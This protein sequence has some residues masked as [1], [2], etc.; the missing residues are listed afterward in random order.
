VKRAGNQDQ[1]KINLNEQ[2]KAM[3]RDG[4]ALAETEQGLI[5][6]IGILILDAAG[7]RLLCMNQWALGTGD[8]HLFRWNQ[9]EQ[10]SNQILF[11]NRPGEIAFAIA[12]FIEWPELDQDII[13][14]SFAGWKLE[15]AENRRAYQRFAQG[16]LKILSS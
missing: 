6:P 16:E 4:A 7:K 11:F 13:Q 2:I 5:F 8:A 3:V 12:P 9:A 10:R 1:D 14:E 15:L